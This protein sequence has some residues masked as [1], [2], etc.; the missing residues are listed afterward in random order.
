MN[1]LKRCAQARSLL[2]VPGNRPERFQK[3]ARSGADAVVLDLEDSVPAADKASARAAIERE[4]ALLQDCD[5][6]WVVRINPS[7][8]AAG[9]DD[10][11]WLKGLRP[12]PAAVM[13]PKAESPQVLAGVHA[14]L[15]GIATLPIIESAAGY[16]A[17]PSLAAA[18]GVLRVAV[19]HIDFMA[20]TGIQCDD[21]ESELA[22][23][24]FAVAIATR[25]NRLAPAIDG[26]TVQ[27]DDEARLRADARRA[28]RYGFGG[29]LCIHPRQVAVLHQALAPTEE[30]LEWARRVIAADAA[31]EGAAVQ[32]DGHMVDLPVVLQ[33]RRTMARAADS[34]S[35]GS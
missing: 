11:A 15:D 31:A 16:A 28:L 25:L 5:V 3:A 4:W 26:V 35:A 17:L 24:R 34:S 9:E 10:L 22:P 1:H 6:P 20:D 21:S 18:A 13:V 7:D 2:F 30:E 8:T 33:A 12:A 27:I 23:L 32:L 29:K 19:G 14:R